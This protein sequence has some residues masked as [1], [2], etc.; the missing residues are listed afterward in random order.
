MIIDY[1]TQKVLNTKKTNTFMS[2]EKEISLQRY[3]NSLLSNYST[4]GK[5]EMYKEASHI[6]DLLNYMNKIKAIMDDRN[7][8]RRFEDVLNFFKDKKLIPWTEA[9]NEKY[10]I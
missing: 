2:K 5:L 6:I 7:N 10:V 1:E 4:A 8:T 9:E 3:I